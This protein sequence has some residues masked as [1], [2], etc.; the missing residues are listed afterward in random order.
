MNISDDR[1]LA[2]IRLSGS[3]NEAV[4]VQETTP[5]TTEKPIPKSIPTTEN[6]LLFFISNKYLSFK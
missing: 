6:I 1:I 4:S 2:I 5:S 3:S